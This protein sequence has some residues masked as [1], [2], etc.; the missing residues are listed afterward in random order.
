[1]FLDVWAYAKAYHRF[2]SLSISVCNGYTKGGKAMS[3]LKKDR[4]FFRIFSLVGAIG[5]TLVTTSMCCARLRPPKTDRGYDNAM[6][7]NREG[8]ILPIAPKYQEQ[9]N[10]CT[11][12]VFQML[13]TYAGHP[14]KQCEIV[15]E[16]IERLNPVAT[17]TVT[18][19]CCDKKTLK[20]SQVCR[21]GTNPNDIPYLM[22]RSPLRSEQKN[23]AL[24]EFFI[25]EELENGR[26]I[27]ISYHFTNSYC[28]DDQR[29]NN[30][31]SDPRCYGHSQLLIGYLPPGKQ[32]NTSLVTHYIVIDPAYG[33]VEEV[34]YPDLVRGRE[35]RQDW[36]WTDGRFVISER[37]WTSSWI[38]M[39]Q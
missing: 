2:D 18:Y 11:I 9:E 27:L 8:V 22:D 25:Q 32:T 21:R 36:P 29:Q 3:S 17:A 31:H 13:R 35:I 20:K 15:N 14:T 38:I 30:P 7:N 19:D 16:R 23:S 12:A 34:A 28:A 33:T 24:S 5:I 6:S 37:P 26:P 10:W 39:P 4:Q 1:M